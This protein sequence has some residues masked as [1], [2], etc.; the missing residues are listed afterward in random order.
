MNKKISVRNL[1]P[2]HNWIWNGVCYDWEFEDGTELF[3]FE[4]SQ[5]RD[6]SEYIIPEWQR[7]H[8]WSEKQQIAYIEYCFTAPLQGGHAVAI[9]LA[10]MHLGN[11]KTFHIKV[12]LIDGLQRTTAVR[13]FLKGEIKIFGR[14]ANEYEFRGSVDFRIH[15]LRVK[16]ER[17]AIE[18]YLSINGTGTPHT[19][20]ELDRVRELLK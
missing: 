18:L 8:V 10:E 2:N 20:D 1:Q 11:G 17:Q 9:I 5:Y 6:Y 15:K 14:T 19:Q 12:F 13:R 16:S 7:G 3:P 4:E